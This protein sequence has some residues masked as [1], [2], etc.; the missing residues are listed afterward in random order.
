MNY[1]KVLKDGRK[2]VLYEGGE[3][4]SVAQMADDTSCDFPLSCSHLNDTFFSPQNP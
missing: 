2:T 1:A 3:R 4:H